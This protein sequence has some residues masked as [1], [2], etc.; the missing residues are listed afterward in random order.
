VNPLWIVLT[1]VAVLALIALILWSRGREGRLLAR[2]RDATQQFHAQRSALESTFLTAAGATG[3]P[4]GL[5]WIG[6]RLDPTVLFAA[7][8]KSGQLYALAGATV[9]FE[10]VEG[11][12]M[13]GVEAVGNLRY[14][15]AVFVHRGGEWTTDGRAIF[16]LEPAQAIERF[17]D[18]LEPLQL[19]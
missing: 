8:R 10:A 9:S 15:T 14:A 11:G 5:R 12:G 4:R 19:D 1:A 3:K 2:R 16:N 18:A 13:E 7:D 6:C 17:G